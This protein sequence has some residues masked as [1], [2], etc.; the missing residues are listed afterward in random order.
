[1]ENRILNIDSKVST[2]IFNFINLNC[3]IIKAFEFS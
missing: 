1:M 2:K 3:L